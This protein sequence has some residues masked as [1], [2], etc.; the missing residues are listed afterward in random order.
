MYARCICIVLHAS[1]DALVFDK[2]DAAASAV[3]ALPVSLTATVHTFTCCALSGQ[4]CAQDVGQ[5]QADHTAKQP[6]VQGLSRP[7]F[8]ADAADVLNPQERPA[9]WWVS[10]K[11][12]L[13][14]DAAVLWF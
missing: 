5:R 12:K 3:S 7:A 9:H 13:A 2:T 11:N 8:A 4:G 10:L 6:A 1:P 14:F